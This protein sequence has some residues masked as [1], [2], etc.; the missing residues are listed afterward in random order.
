MKIAFFNSHILWASHYET[1]LEIALEHINKGDEVTEL[2]CNINLPACDNN[3]YF[4]PEACFRCI[5]KR[6]EGYKI[7]PSNLI[8]KEFLN[9]T[10]DN[11]KRINSL[12]SKFE[13]IKELQNLYIDNFDIGFAVGASII[14]IEQ[15]SKPIINSNLI[16][17]YIIGSAGIYFSIIN[18]LQKNKVDKFYVFN[19]RLAH[20]K[21]VLRACQKMGVDCFL[22]ER[23]NSKDFYSLFKN[24]SIHDAKNTQKEIEKLWNDA[25]NID[26]S[27]KIAND[28]YN[29]RYSGKETNWYSFVDKQKMELPSDWDENKLNIGIFSSTEHEFTSLG[30]EWANPIYKNQEEGIKRII[31][32][33]LSNDLVHFYLRVHPNI[34]FA[35]PDEKNDAHN[36]VSRNLTIIPSDS[37]I[38]SYNLMMNCDKIITFGSMIGIEAAYFGKPS[39]L[40]GKSLYMN[41]GSNYQPKLHEELLKMV[42]SDLEPLPKLGA[43]KYGYFCATFG[44]KFKYYTATDFDSGNFNNYKIESK[45]KMINKIYLFFY[46]KI[47]LLNISENILWKLKERVR[48]QLI[49]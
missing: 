26:E 9:L 34:N 10:E 41:L 35:H 38:S 22:H 33:F 16:N 25:A 23:G 32:D 30:K 45:I 44:T 14:S 5:T 49:K 1:M 11:K 37:S 19:G 17:N 27:T 8:R 3:P 12:Q 13:S 39:I 47:K 42:I 28:Y 4:E 18:Y 6:E 15:H 21:A 40:A 24:Y 48:S 36:F 31:N 2:Y 43:E 46:K 20:T 29:K 7:L